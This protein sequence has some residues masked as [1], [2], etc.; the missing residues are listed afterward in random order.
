MVQPV[1]FTTLTAICAALQPILLPARLEQVYQ[2]DRWTVCLA[3]RTLTGRRWLSLSW[4]RQAARIGIE[5]A[6]PKA[7]DTFTFSQQ[8]W[9]Q[10]GGLALVEIVMISHWERVVALRFAQRPGDPI[11]GQIYVEIMGQY[12]NAVL[13]NQ[14][15]LIVTAAHQVSERQSRLRTIQTG[16]SYELP[17]TPIADTPSLNETFE[18]WQEKIRLIPGKLAKNLTSLYRGLSSVLVR[19]MLDAS[20]IAIDATTETI[21]DVQWRKLFAIWQ[22]WLQTLEHKT[23]HPTVTATGYRVI[24]WDAPAAAT[25]HAH[26]LQRILAHYYGA[27][28]AE[29]RF[30]E[31]QHQLQQR[32]QYWLKR[33]HSKREGFA[34]RLDDAAQMAQVKQQADLLMA[35]LQQWRPGMTQI[36]LLDFESQ[37]PMTIGLSPEKNAVQNAQSLYKKHQKLKRS[38]GAILPLLQEVQTEIDYLAQ[39]ETAIVQLPGDDPAADLIAL[40]AIRDELIGTHYLPPAPHQRATK[41]PEVAAGQPHRF[42]SP[43]GHAILVGRNNRQNDQLTF[44]TATDYDLWFHTQQIPG[45]HVL[46]RVAPGSSPSDA[47]LQLAADLASYFSQARDSEQAPIVY[48]QPKHLHKPK[49]AK[50]GMVIY[51]HETVLWGKPRRGKAWIEK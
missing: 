37:E 35:H 41:G 44:R 18:N 19:S 49:G 43:N 15:G 1:D 14:A 3:L 6:P 12:S 27:R 17:P 10:L 46:L 39:V 45:S 7:P 48:T 8:L 11:V 24:D 28:L 42:V 38:R 2:R 13:V 33:L 30:S 32:L 21:D 25:P 47:D 16:A 23:F 9:H 36:E 26:D 50:P 29:Q 4:H 31:L 5:D 51:D 20:A 40:E 22:V 34:T